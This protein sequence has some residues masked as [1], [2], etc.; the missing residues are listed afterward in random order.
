MRDY[1]EAA[2]A[3]D[4]AQAASAALHGDLEASMPVLNA[5]IAMP[6][7]ASWR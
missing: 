6:V 4:H 2:R 5:V 1:T 3:F 7:T